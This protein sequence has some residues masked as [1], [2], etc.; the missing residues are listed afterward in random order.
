MRSRPGYYLRGT[1]YIA[2]ALTITIIAL[3]IPLRLPFSFIKKQ[4]AM[5]TATQYPKG[6]VYFL[7]HGVS[8]VFESIRRTRAYILGP[9][10]DV[11]DYLQALPRVAGLRQDG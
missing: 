10:N 9:T 11:R 5:S 1:I 7:S 6:E 4:L 3:L 8:F 2:A